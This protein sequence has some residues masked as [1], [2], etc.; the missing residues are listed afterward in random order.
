MLGYDE[1]P[2]PPQL[3]ESLKAPATLALSLGVEVSR[4]RVKSFHPIP[5]MLEVIAEQAP[6]IF[7]F[8]PDRAQI[9][10]LRYRRAVRAIRSRTATLLWTAE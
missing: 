3:E 1:L 2:Y 6:G 5:A 4:L 7:V 8:G 9:P 10:R